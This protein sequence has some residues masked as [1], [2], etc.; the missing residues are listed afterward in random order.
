MKIQI[1][2]DINLTTTQY[3]KLVMDLNNKM[4]LMEN[5]TGIMILKSGMRLKINSYFSYFREEWMN[6][7]Q[8]VRSNNKI[9]I[10]EVLKRTT[11]GI[12]SNGDMDISLSEIA[13]MI[14]NEKEN[15]Y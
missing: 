4:E 13:A 2:P 1:N 7:K 9:A 14:S 3:L 15:A 6:Y 5:S 8:A 12:I 11:G 10:E